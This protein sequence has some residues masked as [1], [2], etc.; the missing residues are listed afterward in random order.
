MEFKNQ[1]IYSLKVN[2]RLE[3]F[4]NVGLQAFDDPTLID[5]RWLNVKNLLNKD[6]F[7]KKIQLNGLSKERFAFA[8]KNFT[9][10]EI[11]IL[12]DYLN[13]CEWFKLFKNILLEFEKNHKSDSPN[14]DQLILPFTYYIK[15]KIENMNFNNIKIEKSGLDHLC[16]II[17][18]Q[19]SKMTYKCL[20][21][22][23]ENYKKSFCL[24]G[25]SGNER[26]LEFI[27]HNYI[28]ADQINTFYCKYPVL[29]RLLTQKVIDLISATELMLFN[30]NEHY[31][32]YKDILNL[33]SNNIADVKCFQGDI[34]NRGKSVTTIL[35]DNGQKIIYKP[36]NANIEKAFYEFVDYFNVTAGLK[37]LYINAA[38]YKKN[39]TI[40]KF[41]ENKSCNS[42]EE[43]K[44]FYY[45]FGELIVLTSLLHGSDFHSENLIAYNKYPVIVDYET[46]FTQYINSQLEESNFVFKGE[47]ND[48][49][50]LSATA[51][52]PL[53]ALNNNVENKGIDV[54]GLSGGDDCMLP[55][56][57]LIIKNLYTDEMHYELDYI[58]KGED[59]NRPIFNSEI[60]TF[61]SYKDQIYAGFNDTLEYIIKN[62]NELCKLIEITFNNLEV[63]Q[64]LKPT[65]V[66]GN[67][68]SY[69]DHPNYLGNM[70]YLERLLD[71]SYSYPHYD[72]KIVLYEVKDLH[73][74]EV[75][76]F[77]TNTSNKYL[78]TSCGD[79][80]ENYYTESV[81]KQVL[82]GIYQLSNKSISY[83]LMKLKIMLGDYSALLADRTSY[84][85][86]K[87]KLLDTKLH[88]N[89]DI[90]NTCLL[91]GKKI[92]SS[93]YFTSDKKNISW[94]YI[95]TKHE[96]PEITYSNDSLYDGR[97]GILLFLHYLSEFTQDEEIMFMTDTLYK[98]IDFN[99]ETIEQSSFYGKASLLYVK[100]KI[101]RFTDKDLI[102]LKEML[103]EMHRMPLSDDIDYLNGLAGYIGLLYRFNQLGIEENLTSLCIQRYVSYL[104]SLID[105]NKVGN[106]ESIGFGHGEIG[107]LYALIIG[108]SFIDK[109]YED[110]INNLINK[111]NERLTNY[112][113]KGVSNNLSWCHGIGG[114]GSGAIACKRHM[115]DIRFDKFIDYSFDEIKRKDSVNMCICH[116]LGGDID[117]LISMSQLY[118]DNAIVKT[119]ISQKI[120]KI[121]SFYNENDCVILD[122]L[123]QFKNI[124]LFTGL[125]GVGYVLLR[126]IYPGKISSILTM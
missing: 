6:L 120:S 72:K 111:I 4:D 26:Y 75:P 29:A 22:E 71:N 85:L 24:S 53:Q 74:L 36:R 55:A 56:K 104:A 82:N 100:H 90:L 58:K 125:S 49:L 122:E 19:L 17:I 118:T 110:E 45:R 88:S 41:V 113:T 99:S 106:I 38:Y 66:Y 109:N 14:N 117:F 3:A 65:A 50:N 73:H 44:E 103:I 87:S 94:K 78:A 108:Q 57:V 76:I 70:M 97:A 13:H 92:I 115:D 93:A 64:V 43:V 62:M 95:D 52:L 80:I 39:F 42:I 28:T 48:I 116:G 119:Y 101:N 30:I 89:K 79:T 31:Y 1:Y 21:I 77:Y 23:M 8:I 112:S 34:H 114:L 5:E 68:L 107:I 10:Y 27:K 69:T 12:Y 86:K 60:Q 35:F 2:E 124:G 96:F 18:N 40:E 123:P 105:S 121:I 51:L 98:A 84:L 32:K 25:N 9:D 20:I 126:S 59:R 16:Q 11:S 54:S 81:L 63:R 83:E 61:N 37:E 46:L 47:E 7:D 102:K 67:L 33:T 91:I 15:K